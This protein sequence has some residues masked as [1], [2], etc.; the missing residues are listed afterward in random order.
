MPESSPS[1][2]SHENVNLLS[3]RSQ[4]TAQHSRIAHSVAGGD[5]EIVKTL[6][7]GIIE[8]EPRNIYTQENAFPRITN[9]SITN[10]TEN[11]VTIRVTSPSLSLSFTLPNQGKIDK[12]ASLTLSIQQNDNIR[13]KT[14]IRIHVISSNGLFSPYIHLL[15]FHPPSPVIRSLHTLLPLKPIS[16]LPTISPLLTPLSNPPPDPSSINNSH[17]GILLLALQNTK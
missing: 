7:M 3:R 6:S 5:T 12:G 16:S 10:L 17:L 11:G 9:H 14:K 8:V 1:I 2:E 15:I 4:I 13:C